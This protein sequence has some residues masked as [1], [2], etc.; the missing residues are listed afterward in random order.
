MKKKY[1]FFIVFYLFLSCQPNDKN[2]CDPSLVNNDPYLINVEKD[3]SVFFSP[4]NNL[5]IVLI[6]FLETATESIDVAIYDITNKNISDALILAHKNGIS[7]RVYCDKGVQ[8]HC[9]RK[10]NKCK[11]KCSDDSCLDDCHSDDLKC[12]DEKRVIYDMKSSGIE[13]YIANPN[14]WI[15]VEAYRAIMHNKFIIVDQKAVLTGS[16]NFSKN[17]DEN[18]RENFIIIKNLLVALEYQKE[19]DRYWLN[20]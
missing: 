18:N 4:N 14:N 5:E 17:A 2:K 6:N 20:P 16:Y 10:Y 12:F 1:F 15:N 9:D 13:L 3:I 7:V 8:N 11:E 19:F